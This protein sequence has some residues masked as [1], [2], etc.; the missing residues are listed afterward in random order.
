MISKG[1]VKEAMAFF[2]G[3]ERSP[4]FF[5]DFLDIL[6]ASDKVLFCHNNLG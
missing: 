2:S 6:F 1:M 5:S 3:I 4:E